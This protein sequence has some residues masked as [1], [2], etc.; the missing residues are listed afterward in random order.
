M[1]RDTP[2]PQRGKSMCAQSDGTI[3]YF[4]WN[5]LCLKYDEVYE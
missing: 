1:N 5:R 4:M 3:K 2:V